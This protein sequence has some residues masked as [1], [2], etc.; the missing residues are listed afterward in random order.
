MPFGQASGATLG[1][2]FSQI[3]V[4]GVWVGNIDPENNFSEIKTEDGKINLNIPE[5]LEE[6]QSAEAQREEAMLVIRPALL[7]LMAGRHTS[8][9][10]N[11]MMRDPAGTKAS[12]PAMHR[13]TQQP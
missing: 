12:V 10:A 13:T 1:E 3:I 11:T 5:L 2:I 9:N 8:M 4:E 6:L 7:I